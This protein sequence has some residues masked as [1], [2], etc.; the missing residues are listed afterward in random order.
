MIWFSASCNFTILPNSLGL[1]ALPLRITS[2]EGSNRLRSLPSLRVLPRKMRALVCFIT[3]L[4]RALQRQV[5]QHARRPLPALGDLLG[6]ALFLPHH[7]AR[8]IQQLAV[9]PLQFV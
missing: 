2:V 1:P 7:S 8:C 6:K 5:L 9:A 3:C 4:T